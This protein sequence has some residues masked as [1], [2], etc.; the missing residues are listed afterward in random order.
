VDIR[1][2]DHLI[3]SGSDWVSLASTPTLKNIFET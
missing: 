3:V 2:R 1:L